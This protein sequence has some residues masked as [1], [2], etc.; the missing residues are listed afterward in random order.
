M[1]ANKSTQDKFHLHKCASYVEHMVMTGVKR[2]VLS[3]REHEP[4]E[5]IECGLLVTAIEW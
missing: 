1:E 2:D 3:G 4:E 5:V